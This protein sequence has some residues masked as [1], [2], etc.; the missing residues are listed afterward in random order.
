ME[1]T[2]GSDG[3]IDGGEG[4][5]PE[6][7]AA[8]ALGKA[9]SCGNSFEAKL[10][11]RT[12]GKKEVLSMGVIRE[13]LTMSGYDYPGDNW[14]L[15]GVYSLNDVIL[16]LKKRNNPE[17]KDKIK[18]IEDLVPELRAIAEKISPDDYNPK[19]ALEE[20]RSLFDRVKAISL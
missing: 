11:R 15:N 20:I 2:L 6:K 16:F 17:D 5:S 13:A 10:K 8:Q 1:F 12:E 4:E 7:K 3:R 9:Q 18:L 19:K 14:A